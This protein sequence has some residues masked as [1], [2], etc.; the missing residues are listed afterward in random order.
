M[1]NKEPD[2]IRTYEGKDG[3][4]Y[5]TRKA[6]NEEPIGDGSEGY[7]TEENAYRAAKRSLH[8]DV[9]IAR[10]DGRHERFGA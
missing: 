7:V 10:P 6:G 4:W 9:I 3:Q 5:W 1:E 2:I 8:G